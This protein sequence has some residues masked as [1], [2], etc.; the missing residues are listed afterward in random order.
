MAVRR[1]IRSS[2]WEPLFV[3]AGA[4]SLLL[5][6]MA[7]CCAS[8]APAGAQNTHGKPFGCRSDGSCTRVG[9]SDMYEGSRA[10][11]RA[12]GPVI[13]VRVGTRAS[14]YRPELTRI[15]VFRDGNLV[16]SRRLPALCHGCNAYAA[17][18]GNDF[19]RFIQL[20]GSPEKEIVI[21][22]YSGGAH[23]CLYDVIL[24]WA[25][26]GSFY[27]W[28]MHD[29][30]DAGPG[31]R[32]SDLDYDGRKEFRTGDTRFAYLFG[33]YAESQ[34]P[35]RVWEYSGGYL[36]DRTQ[37]FP[38]L[39]RRDAAARLR[40]YRRTR[41][42]W[43]GVRSSLA[44]YVADQ[45]LLGQCRRGFRLVKRAIRRGDLRP[46][47]SNPKINYGRKFF[48]RLRRFLRR[49]GYLA[50]RPSASAQGP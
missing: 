32:F 2:H 7:M 41:G 29:F 45:C 6:T 27:R 22:M 33:A 37:R 50:P 40:V 13:S 20:D 15:R 35:P 1:G 47:R 14:S 28:T 24:G 49:A 34:F 5:A 9:R 12:A 42:G 25:T 39:A 8:V 4:M 18:D 23:C 16:L 48:L 38:R 46:P 26:A 17:K 10:I 3:R 11:A 19:I 30:G 44:A 36:L 43:F 21:E 31:V